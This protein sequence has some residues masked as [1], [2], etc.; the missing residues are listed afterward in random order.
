MHVPFPIKQYTDVIWHDFFSDITAIEYDKFID[1]PTPR[2][3]CSHCKYFDKKPKACS[4]YG[5]GSVT[6]FWVILN[7]D[8]ITVKLK[9]IWK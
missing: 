4:I 1:I 8:K 3:T 9:E 5:R 6:V 7:I 2:Q